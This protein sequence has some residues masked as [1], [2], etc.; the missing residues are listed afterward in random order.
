MPDFASL[1]PEVAAEVKLT[2]ATWVY[3]RSPFVPGHRDSSSTVYV[4]IS[5]KVYRGTA[6]QLYQRVWVC[7]EDA[8]FRRTGPTLYYRIEQ[9]YYSIGR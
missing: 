6:V 3:L 1:A 8:L 2:L 9:Q 4:R 5:G 7:C